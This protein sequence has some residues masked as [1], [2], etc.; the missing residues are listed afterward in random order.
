MKKNQF[1]VLRGGLLDSAATSRKEFVSAY[2][3]NTR[4]MGVLGMYMHFKLPDNLVQR[5]LH[6]F[7]YFDAEEYGF[8][9]YHSVLGENRTRIFEIENSLIGGLGGKKIPLTEKQAQYLLQEYAEFNRAHNIPLPEGLSEYEFLLNEKAT[10]SEPELY[11]LMQKQC[12]RPE[13][14]YESINYFLMRIFGRDFKAAAFLSDRDILLDVFPEYDAGTF[15][16]NTIEPTDA[17]NTF[18]C[19]SLVEFRNSY[20]IVLTEI[21]LSGLTVCSFER[22]SIMKISPIEAAM[23][24]SR[25]EF[26]TVYEM[27]EEPDSF[28]TETTPKA[29]TAMVTPH[30]TGKL[31][32]I[33]H[34]DNKHVARKEYRL[35]EDVL[36]MYFVSD[37]GQVIAAAYTLED[38][39][40]LEKDLAGST[41]SKSLIPTQRY[42][43]Q[44]PV[45]YEFIQSTMDRFETFVDII[46]NNPGDEI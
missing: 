21:T 14:A 18:L 25:S 23:L 38:I 31:Y 19:Q 42:E 5:D 41:I 30:D 35:N 2:I 27:L 17:P 12:V 36:G 45:L 4:L 7:F 16:K 43:F 13:N 11:I 34:S 15:C 1:T 24:L 40:L 3:T 29:M 37:A 33:F 9:T 28:S 46:Q 6:Q 32:M 26:V 39:Y 22:N 8:E 44:E 20:Y 10:L